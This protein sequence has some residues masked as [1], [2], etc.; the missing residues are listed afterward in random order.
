[1]HGDGI[2]RGGHVFKS[3]RK[4]AGLQM[5]LAHIAD[6]RDVRVVNGDGKIG[7]VFLCC[8]S[9]LA[10]CGGV[11]VS[12]LCSANRSYGSCDGEQGNGRQNERGGNFESA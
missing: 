7:L 11:I 8:R 3:Q 2:D 12:G 1:M 10:F 6:E 5:Y 4:C 9:G